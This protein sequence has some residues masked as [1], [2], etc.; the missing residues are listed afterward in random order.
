MRTYTPDELNAVLA[1]HALYLKGD[2]AGACADLR[3]AYLSGANLRSADLS[4]A[5]LR[6]ADLRS[7]DLRSADLSGANLRSANLRSAN[8]RSADLYGADLYGADLRGAQNLILPPYQI[9][10]EEGSFIGW[11]AVRGG[12]VLKLEILEDAKRV[13]T[14]IGRKCRASAVKVLAAYH[15]NGSPCTAVKVF[16][17]IH[18]AEFLYTLE[19]ISVAPEFDPSPFAECTSG[20]HFFLT[21]VEAESYNG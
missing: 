18:S 19:G 1:S 15:T 17:S 14:P 3:G 2:P 10:P 20:L 16:S 5:N 21:R 8:L 7:A 6:S 11:K 4:G 12:I 13:S 9:V